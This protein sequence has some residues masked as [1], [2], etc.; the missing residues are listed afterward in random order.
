MLF[1]SERFHI[2]HDSRDIIWISTYGG[3]LF[4]YDVATDELQRYTSDIK[5]T[6]YLTSNYLQNVMEDR[7]GSIWVCSEFTGLT[8]LSIMNEGALRIFPENESL[9]DRSNTIR[10]ITLLNNGDICIGTRTGGVYTYDQELNQKGSKKHFASNIYSIARDNQNKEWLG[11][12][13][14]G[15][16][17]RAHV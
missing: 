10:M 14:N 6:S 12:R 7:S 2:V 13:G 17:G 1:R 15:Q 8:R 3:G 4:S 16:I 5:G 9:I 11:S